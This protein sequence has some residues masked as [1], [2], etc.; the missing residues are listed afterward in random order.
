M[1]SFISYL[2]D[3]NVN[4]ESICMT[5]YR[6]NFNTLFME[7]TIVDLKQILSLQNIP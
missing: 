2:T 1:S 7:R 4:D 3:S 6:S 5:N